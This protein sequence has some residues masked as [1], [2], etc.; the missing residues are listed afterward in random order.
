MRDGRTGSGMKKDIKLDEL[1]FSVYA[2]Y[3]KP[4]NIK[5]QCYGYGV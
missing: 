3:V 2:N 1:H 4:M 5:K